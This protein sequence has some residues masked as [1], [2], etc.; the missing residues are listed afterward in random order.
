MPKK[1]NHAA[2]AHALLSASGAEL[3]L[4]C[5]ASAASQPKWRAAQDLGAIKTNDIIRRLRRE[6]RR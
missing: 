1:I 5:P 3:W 4:H 2:R 6:R